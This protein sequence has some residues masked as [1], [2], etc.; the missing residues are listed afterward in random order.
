MGYKIR[1]S[2]TAGMLDSFLNLYTVYKVYIQLQ[3]VVYSRLRIY[4]AAQNFILMSTI[5][6]RPKIDLK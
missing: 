6:Y 4:I 2:L 1:L 3:Q 5:E